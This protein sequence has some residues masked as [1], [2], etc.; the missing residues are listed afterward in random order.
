MSPALR[1]VIAE[2]RV[3]MTTGAPKHMAFVTNG[4]PAMKTNCGNSISVHVENFLA[5][6]KTEIVDGFSY[7]LVTVHRIKVDMRMVKI[8]I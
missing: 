6:K 5:W 2:L 1:E 8:L 4:L 3:P 7:F